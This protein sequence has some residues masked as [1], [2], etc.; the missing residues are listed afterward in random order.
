M[1]K[2]GILSQYFSKSEQKEIKAKFENI[3]NSEAGT[4]VKK[5][6][7]YIDELVTSMLVASAIAATI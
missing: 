6:V 5:M 1:D 2:A 7:Q 4:L 3:K